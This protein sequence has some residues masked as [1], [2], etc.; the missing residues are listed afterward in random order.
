VTITNQSFTHL[1]SRKTHGIIKPAEQR[2]EKD[3]E[4]QV[5]IN[6]RILH[7]LIGKESEK[8]KKKYRCIA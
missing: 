5:K 2:V 8:D 4:N 3:Q 7:T 6:L 1:Y